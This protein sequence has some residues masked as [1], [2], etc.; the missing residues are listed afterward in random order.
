MVKLEQ[1]KERLDIKNYEDE[2]DLFI[3]DLEKFGKLKASKKAQDLIYIIMLERRTNS[4]NDVEAQDIL[5]SFTMAEVS[6]EL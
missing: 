6:I 5:D 4:T 3:P 1:Y 2:S